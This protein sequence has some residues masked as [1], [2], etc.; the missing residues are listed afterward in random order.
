LKKYLKYFA[1]KPGLWLI[2]GVIAVLLGG[3]LILGT[4]SARETKK[5]INE[6]FNAQQLSLARNATEILTVNFRILKRE[7]TG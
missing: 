7:L 2:T 6:D 1:R 4:L 5:I 3:A